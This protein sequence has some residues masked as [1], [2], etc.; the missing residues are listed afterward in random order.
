MQPQAINCK[1]P[2]IV[3]PFKPGDFRK[4]RAI[5]KLDRAK[6]LL[7]DFGPNS[8]LI[9]KSVVTK[10]WSWQPYGPFGWGHYQPASCGEAKFMKKQLRSLAFQEA[11]MHEF[12]YDPPE[13]L[14]ACGDV[15][16]WEDKPH[17][18]AGELR[19]LLMVW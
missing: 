12:A 2:P 8:W 19:Y 16:A 3:Q 14:C 10:V 15:R 6:I 18:Q 5:A 4:H 7:D 17:L 13:S 9:V 11:R 1:L